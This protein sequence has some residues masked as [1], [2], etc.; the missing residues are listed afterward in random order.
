MPRLPWLRRQMLLTMAGIKG[1]FLAGPIAP[2]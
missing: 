2:V 1:G